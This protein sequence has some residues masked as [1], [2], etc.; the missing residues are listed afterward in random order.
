[1]IFVYIYG[2]F[3]DFIVYGDS[4]IMDYVGAVVDEIALEGLD[5][6]PKLTS[7]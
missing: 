6:K 1:V 3:H 4:D 5:G 7:V 2:G